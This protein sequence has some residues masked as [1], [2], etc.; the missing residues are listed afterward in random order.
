MLDAVEGLDHG[1]LLLLLEDADQH[2]QS[3]ALIVVVPDSLLPLG[4]FLVE[5][6]PLKHQGRTFD[7]QIPKK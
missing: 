7:V 4:L 2:H 6:Q 3:F 1:H 5:D